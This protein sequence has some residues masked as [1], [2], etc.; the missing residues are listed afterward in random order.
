MSTKNYLFIGLIIAAM[1]VTQSCAHKS[2]EADLIIHNAIIHSLDAENRTYDAMAIRDGRI[3]ELGV[4]LQI[5]NKYKS[6]TVIDAMQRPIFPGL[7]D[8][9]CHFLGYGLSRQNVDLIGTNSFEEVL[10]RTVEHQNVYQAEWVVGRG[11]DQNDWEDKTFPDNS[12]LDSLFP[13]TPVLLRRVDGH[14]A[15]ANSMA[16][17]LA[18]ITVDTK[19]SGGEIGIVDGKLTGILV[20]N[21]VDLVKDIIPEPSEELKT[22]A[23]LEA[24]KNCF[25][26]GLTTVDD[27]GLKWQEI[28][29]LQK[30]QEEGKVKMRVYAMASDTEE[31][32]AYF[33]KSGPIK[34]DR[35]SVRSFKFYADGALGSRGACLLSPYADMIN[36]H[37]GFMLDSI[38][39][40]KETAQ[41]LY[42]A[43][44]QMCT[45]CIGDSANRV[46]LNVYGDVLGGVNDFRWRIEH[47]QVVH[48]QD[49]EKFGQY[50]IIPS[51]QP[52][53]ATSDMYW[54]GE[55]LGNTRL[56][57]AYAYQELKLQLGMVALGT[58]FPIE[59]IS[60]LNTFYAATVRKDHDNYP[61]DGFQ[62]ENA[63]TRM[64]ALKGMT[65]WAALSNFE[66]M[67]KGTLEPGKFGDFVVLDRDI[68]KV[69]DDQLLDT[70]V[71]LTVIG[72][73]IVYHDTFSAVKIRD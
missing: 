46:I 69:A 37:T 49:I 53:H 43:G 33:L 28:E 68:L 10:E 42:D 8:A 63:L 35:L 70:K 23:W 24:Q 7:I 40:F 26:V 14:G 18:G 65:I 71:L 52:T 3:L 1:L 25:A 20:D 61:Q 4:E 50:S 66:E 16:L 38:G 15:L 48:K 17:A 54:A 73:E 44:F 9:H 30:L 13:G 2:E 27:A 19:V 55:R 41:L 12:Q 57:R 29:L 36:A 11:W 6:A 47:A 51:I 32:L 21:A 72:G 45:H 56:R 67:E 64:E 34:T 39:H 59:G 22:Q 58:D 5:L 62:T 31:N 60:P